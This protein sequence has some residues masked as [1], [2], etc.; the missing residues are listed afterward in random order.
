MEGD[1]YFPLSF[2]ALTLFTKVTVQDIVEFSSG[3]GGYYTYHFAGKLQPNNMNTSTNIDFS[4]YN[5]HEVGFFVEL[6]MRTAMILF[7]VQWRLAF[8]DVKINPIRNEMSQ[9]NGFNIRI[10]YLF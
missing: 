7:G 1:Y 9:I 10:G 6:E 4:K 8:T 5:P 2:C 3:V